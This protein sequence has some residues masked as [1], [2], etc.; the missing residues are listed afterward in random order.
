MVQERATEAGFKHTQ[1]IKSEYFDC[2]N[3]IP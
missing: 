2:Q 3:L 1:E